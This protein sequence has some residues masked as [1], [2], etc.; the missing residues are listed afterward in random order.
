MGSGPQN[1]EQ[2]FVTIV[3]IVALLEQEKAKAPKERFYSSKTLYPL[4]ILSKPY[5]DRYEPGT[6][7]QYDGRRGNAVEHVSKFIDTLSPYVV[8]DMVDIMCDMVDVFCTKYF[9]GK[10][11]MTLVTL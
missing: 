10:E 11:T 6:F 4:R 9:H 8:D 5:P 3:D 1:T 7:A 2:C